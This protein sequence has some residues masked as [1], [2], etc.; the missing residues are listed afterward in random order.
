MAK[1]Y[2][3]CGLAF[4]GKSTL[5]RRISEHTGGRLFA[6]D[7]MWMEEDKIKPVPQGIGGWKY[8][9]DKA[10]TKSLRLLKEG[11]S[12]I[13]DENNPKRG[14]R[15]EFRRLAEEV[16][17]EAVVVYVDTSLDVVREREQANR[18]SPNRHDVEPENFEK[19]LK[20]ME[21][22]TPDENV[23]AFTPDMEIEEFLEK[24]K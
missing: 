9:R 22:P 16:G 21:A 2:I 11:V 4:S 14:N 7:A 6:F 1:L 8:I 12:V 20:D 10:K 17:A 18:L 3:M 19:V 15:E 13:Y 24:L 23:L 5:A